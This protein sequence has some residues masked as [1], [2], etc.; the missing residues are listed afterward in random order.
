M[1]S[2]QEAINSHKNKLFYEEYYGRINVDGIIDNL[3]NFENFFNNAKITHTSWVGLYR[4]GFDQ[5][6]KG[7]RVLELGCGDCENAAIMSLLGAEVYGV[8][9]A[10]TSGAII[11]Q[12]NAKFPFERPL[13]FIFGDFLEAEIPHD[14]FDIV[15][16]KAFVHHLT[17]EQEVLFTEKIVSILKKD[18]IVRYFEPAVNSKILDQVRYLIPLRDRPS[19]LQRE[20]FR[21]W[22]LSDPHPERDN[23]SAGYRKIGQK[24]FRE[25]QI[26]CLGSIEKLHRL[27]PRNVNSKKFRQFAFRAETYLPQWIQSAFA[28]SQTVEYRYPIK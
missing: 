7:K 2:N 17:P 1:Q 12:L 11:E 4:D 28:R 14:F 20:K 6:L 25:T 21:A 3:N 27:F 19:F 10:Q 15:V 9:I 18:G 5:K 16:G 13:H 8:D 26:Y 23:S 22:K 24:Y